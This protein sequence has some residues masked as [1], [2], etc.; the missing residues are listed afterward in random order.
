M[1]ILQTNEETVLREALTNF[2]LNFESSSCEKR[3]KQMLSKLAGCYDRST[4]NAKLAEHE[5]RKAFAVR[6]SLQVQRLGLEAQKW[7]LITAA[8][9]HVMELVNDEDS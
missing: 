9:F 2:V 8:I 7:R 1:S 3:K 6:N 5:A 4:H